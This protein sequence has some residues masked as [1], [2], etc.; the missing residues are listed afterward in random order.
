MTGAYLTIGFVCAL[1]G[2]EGFMLEAEGLQLMI[3]FGKNEE[4]IDLAHVV[5]P[6]L[7]IFKNGDGEKWHIMVAVNTTS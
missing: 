1:H 2:N 6:L 4:N 7:G 5:I 3:N